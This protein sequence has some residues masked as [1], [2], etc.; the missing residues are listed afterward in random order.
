MT[1]EHRT[2]SEIRR[3]IASERAELADA[4]ATLRD[5]VRAKSRPVRRVVVALIATL[6]AVVV[7]R[8]A[9]RLRCCG[10]GKGASA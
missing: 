7:W 1:A 9:R 4:V 8:V 2:E 3:E 5:D 6:G 10:R